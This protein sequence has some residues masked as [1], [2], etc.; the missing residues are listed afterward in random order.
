MSATPTKSRTAATRSSTA[1]KTGVREQAAQTTRDNILK[2]ATKVFA[3]YGYE[4]GSVEKISKAAK[5]FDRMIYYYFGSK[6]GLFIEVLEEIYRRMN[7]SEATLDI[8]L[9]EPIES[10]KAVVRFVSQY[11]RKHPE[12]VTLLNTE[13]LHKGKHISKSLRARE[14]SSPAVSVIEQVLTSGVAQGVFRPDMRARDLYLLIASMGYFYQSNRYTLSAFL[15][16]DI[17]L[18]EAVAHWDDFMID[19]VLRTVKA[20]TAP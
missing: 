7:D 4:G 19:V 10:L 12:F 5:S 9:G 13:N 1:R 16:E 17:D 11:Y 20:E 15:G 3:R 18:P 8:R 2:A 14:Y 6:E